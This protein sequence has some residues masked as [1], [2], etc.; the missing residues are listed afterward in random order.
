MHRQHRSESRE[1][2]RPEV[3]PGRGI[4]HLAGMLWCDLNGAG[5]GQVLI[6]GINPG[7][8]LGNPSRSV[9]VAGYFLIDTQ[10][11]RNGTIVSTHDSDGEMLPRA[12]M[13]R[14]V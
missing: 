14:A 9:P 3:V 11:E 12:N 8:G 2:S 7:A 6:R 10:P 13:G 4:L 5:G 1:F